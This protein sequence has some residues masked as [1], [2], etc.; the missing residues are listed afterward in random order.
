MRALL[1]CLLLGLTLQVARVSADEREPFANYI[2]IAEWSE[3]KHRAER[4]EATAQYELANAYY[5]PGNRGGISQNYKRALHW[6]L[7]A[8]LRGHASAQH[9]VGVI[10][11]N[12]DLGKI[13]DVE[14]VAW[15][16]IAAQNGDAAG[17]RKFTEFNAGLN[18]TQKLSAQKRAQFLLGVLSKA[19]SG[20]E[21]NVTRLE[22]P[23]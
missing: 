1:F 5:Q 11:I 20:A 15:F 8:A 6:W 4:G 9:N 22:M 21:Y 23:H 19:Q 2:Y 7:Q 10:Y 12:G 13:D 3:L 18:E 17:K 16:T 14:G